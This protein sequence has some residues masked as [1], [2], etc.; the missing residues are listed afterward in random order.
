MQDTVEPSA[1]RPVISTELPSGTVPPD[2]DGVVS[3][4]LLSVFDVP[5]SD[6]GSRSGAAGADGAEVSTLIESPPVGPAV[7][8]AG[9]TT[10][11]EIAHVPSASVPRSQLLTVGDFT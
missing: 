8:P 3:L 11:D 10:D 9:S 6:A 7:L 4:V 1:L 5:E 2:I